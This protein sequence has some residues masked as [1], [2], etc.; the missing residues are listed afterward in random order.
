MRFGLSNEFAA[1][2]IAVAR[3]PD[4]PLDGYRGFPTLKSN[5]YASIFGSGGTLPSTSGSHPSLIIVVQAF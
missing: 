5:L 1:E 2:K 3:I 4:A